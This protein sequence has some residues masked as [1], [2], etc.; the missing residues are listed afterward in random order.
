MVDFIEE[1]INRIRES[2]EE[3]TSIEVIL[4]HQPSRGEE[5]VSH[6]KELGVSDINRG[7]FNTLLI[8]TFEE[9]IDSICSL[10]YVEDIE[11]NSKGEV[12]SAGN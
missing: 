6:L 8:S 12:L 3:D 10:D 9:K 4:G 7:P 1:A 2:P 5:V 11:L